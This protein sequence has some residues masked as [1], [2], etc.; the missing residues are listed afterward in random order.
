MAGRLGKRTV[1][2]VPVL[3]D[4]FAAVTKIWIRVVCNSRPR[5]TLAWQ[6]PAA[7][8]NAAVASTG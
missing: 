4:R 7:G 5:R 1:P 2:G 8:F 6:T 3:R